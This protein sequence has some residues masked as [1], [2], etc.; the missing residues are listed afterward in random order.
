MRIKSI[1]INALLLVGSACVLTGCNEEYIP[2]SAEDAKVQWI[3]AEGIEGSS[4]TLEQKAT[5]AIHLSFFPESA[6]NK[7]SYTFTYVSSNEDVATVSEDGIITAI[8]VGKTTVTVIPS[9]NEKLRLSFTVNV[10]AGKVAVE[11]ISVSDAVKDGILFDNPG[12]KFNL[13][14]HVSALPTGATNPALTY[15]VDKPEIVTVDELGM[16]SAIAPGTAAVTVTSVEN[17]DIKVTIPI[18]VKDFPA[19]VLTKLNRG[20][21]VVTETDEYLTVGT[22][23]TAEA[24]R[25]RVLDGDNETTI[26]F[27]KPGKTRPA[28][29]TPN[30]FFVIDRNNT[31]EFLTFSV[32]QPTGKNNRACVTAVTIYGKDSADGAWKVIKENISIPNSTV[33]GSESGEIELTDGAPLTYRYIKVEIT[34]WITQSS[35]T[36]ELAEFYLTG[37]EK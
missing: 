10:I 21:W 33:Q 11:G 12:L 26:K 28:D 23:D 15:T 37:Y 1:T 16:L 24:V 27:D 4:I 2:A 35:S 34:G 13:A 19:K 5:F 18:Q 32:V 17:T 31:C 6:S 22:D 8:Q 20:T 9:Y 29:G 7:D 14:Q 25:A 3:K 30:S 36:M